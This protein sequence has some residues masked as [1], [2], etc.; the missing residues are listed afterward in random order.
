MQ[1][2][3]YFS[4]PRLALWAAL[5]FLLTLLLILARDV[6]DLPRENAVFV[7]RVAG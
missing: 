2:H 5:L 7:F 3:P 6:H 4:A 1:R